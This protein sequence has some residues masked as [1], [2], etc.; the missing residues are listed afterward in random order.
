MAKP[1]LICPTMNWQSMKVA[2]IQL[3]GAT[4]AQMGALQ[5]LNEL[6]NTCLYLTMISTL[7]IIQKKRSTV[8]E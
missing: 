3:W 2:P 6:R 5:L 7:S 1:Q 4:R 8:S